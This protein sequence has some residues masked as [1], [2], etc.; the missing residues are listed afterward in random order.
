MPQ[1]A[2]TTD[3]RDLLDELDRAHA[4]GTADGP[5]RAVDN[6]TRF[7]AEYRYEI[8]DDEGS[9]AVCSDDNDA[10]ATTGAERTELI[11]AAVNRLPRLAAALRNVLLF[12]DTID[13]QDERATA[14]AALIR[15]AVAEAML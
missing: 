8:L 2:T 14:T 5:W 10:T 7:G 15:R 12:A 9:V 1:Q 3:L 11:V 6:G 13:G 4:A